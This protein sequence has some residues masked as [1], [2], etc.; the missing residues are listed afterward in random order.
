MKSTGLVN[1]P[2]DIV[3]CHNIFMS[4][5]RQSREPTITLPPPLQPQPASHQPLSLP[6]RLSLETY[7]LF[8][9]IYLPLQD[10]LHHCCFLLL[11]PPAVARYA[12]F[13]FRARLLHIY[14]HQEPLW[15]SIKVYKAQH[16]SMPL[17]K[18]SLLC[19]FGWHA[20]SA[21]VPYLL[22]PDP[23]P[24]TSNVAASSGV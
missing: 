19:W 12:C 7:S 18:S 3:Y 23:P 5:R 16:T 17:S 21:A 24:G 2:S 11:Q 4:F 20:A 14:P 15:P 6:F 1:P 10:I 9:T 8:Q 22:D 13:S